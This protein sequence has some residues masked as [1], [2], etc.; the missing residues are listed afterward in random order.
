MQEE[1]LK[2]LLEVS[3]QQLVIMQELL[4]K[5]KDNEK[6]Q[7]A[8]EVKQLTKREIQ[9]TEIDVIKSEINKYKCFKAAVKDNDFIVSV[10]HI[11]D[12]EEI[13]LEQLRR[14]VHNVSEQSNRA[15]IKDIKKYTYSCLHKIHKAYN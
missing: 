14:I 12:N 1:T 15:T 4:K 13:T 8:K 7:A 10:K 5:E 3:K 11:I 2:E 9:K 6:L